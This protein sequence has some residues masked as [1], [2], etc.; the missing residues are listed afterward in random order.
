MTLDEAMAE[1][2]LSV[3]D[4]VAGAYIDMT[5]GMLLSL[6]TRDS[7]AGDALDRVAAATADLFAGAS[8]RRLEESVGADPDGTHFRECLVFGET[9]LHVFVRSRTYRDHMVS[10]VCRRDANV[11]MVLAKSRLTVDRLEQ[12]V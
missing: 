3:P 11:G 4:C 7:R 5:T 8:I 9:M 1:A 6:A 2:V 12:A 10:Y